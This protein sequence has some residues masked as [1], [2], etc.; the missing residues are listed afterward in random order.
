MNYTTKIK[1]GILEDENLPQ[2]QQEL[3]PER[4]LWSEVIFRALHD[5]QTYLL[6]IRA[7]FRTHAIQAREWILSSSNSPMSFQ[8]A[9]NAALPK[10]DLQE[11]AIERILKIA[12][13]PLPLPSDSSPQIIYP[14]PSLDEI[15]AC[16]N[17]TRGHK[18]DTDVSVENIQQL[19]IF[20]FL[21]QHQPSPH[22]HSLE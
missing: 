3:L 4:N 19:Q 14:D 11:A 18:K 2:N 8:W 20:R 16:L 5:I 22:H 7:D 17:R 1:A 13:P 15:S 6:T 12:R 10:Q 9:I 21:G